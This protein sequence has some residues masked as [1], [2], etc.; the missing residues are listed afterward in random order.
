MMGRAQSRSPITRVPKYKGT[1][2]Q[3]PRATRTANHRSKASW[4]NHACPTGALRMAKHGG[5][6]LLPHKHPKFTK[7]PE[8]RRK[9]RYCTQRCRDPLT[10][11]NS[12]ETL[13]KNGAKAQQPNAEKH[14]LKRCCSPETRRKERYVSQRHRDPLLLFH[15]SQKRNELF[16]QGDHLIHHTGGDQIG[17]LNPPQGRAVFHHGEAHYIN[18][19]KASNKQNKP[20]HGSEGSEDKRN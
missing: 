19:P 12:Q 10:A 5:K 8:P 16:K 18:S 11:S 14:A 2:N 4:G 6:T 13:P 9:A 1:N 17:I 20:H 15:R 7:R 3:E